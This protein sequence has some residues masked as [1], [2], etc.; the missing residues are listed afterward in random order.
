MVGLG[1]GGVFLGVRHHRR[2]LQHN[3]VIADSGDSNSSSVEWRGQHARHH[4][5]AIAVAASTIVEGSYRIDVGGVVKCDG[6]W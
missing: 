1:S 2:S 6:R 3:G 5:L 4:R